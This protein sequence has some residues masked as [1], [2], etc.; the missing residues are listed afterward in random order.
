M[1]DSNDPN[2]R[3]GEAVDA[4]RLDMGLSK[5]ELASLAKVARS[6]IAILINRGQ[7]PGREVTRARIEAALGWTHGSFDAVLDGAE[8]TLLSTT[9]YPLS[10]AKKVL[11]EQLSQISHE[12]HCAAATAEALSKRLQVLGDLAESAAQLATRTR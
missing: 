12:A 6:T 2:Q 5:T 8:P 10:G 1:R 9:E 11:V 4:A 7:V 3:L